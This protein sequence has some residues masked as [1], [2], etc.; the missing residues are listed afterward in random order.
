[1]SQCGYDQKDPQ[2]R[3]EARANDLAATCLER[4]LYT[5]ESN[6]LLAT[7]S[8][9]G[10]VIALVGATETFCKSATECVIILA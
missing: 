4:G 6:K 8:T 1:M 3:Q 7:L 9:T 5:G 2:S 10:I